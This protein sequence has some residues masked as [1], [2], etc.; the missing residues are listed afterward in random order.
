M[1]VKNGALH[2]R[3]S[4]DSALYPTVPSKEKDTRKRLHRADN[5]KGARPTSSSSTLERKIR[6]RQRRKRGKTGHF[7]FVDTRSRDSLWRVHKEGCNFDGEFFAQTAFNR[8]S[9]RRISPS[10]FR[11]RGDNA[12]DLVSFLRAERRLSGR[13]METIEGRSFLREKLREVG[14]W[15][16]CVSGNC[17]DGNEAR[18]TFVDGE[19]GVERRRVLSRSRVRYE[20]GLAFPI[21]WTRGI[22]GGRF[23]AIPALL[24]AS[25]FWKLFDSSSMN[26]SVG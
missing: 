24:V 5:A 14:L 3:T 17:R 21:L 2:Q 9:I 23:H 20:H 13:W 6:Q 19:T 1:Q 8:F 26:N 7:I 25:W 10:P 15:N 18:Y 22:K 4:S 12:H 11:L 16:L